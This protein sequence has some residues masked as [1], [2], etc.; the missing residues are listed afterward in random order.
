MNFGKGKEDVLIFLK[1][2]A[3]RKV[4]IFQSCENVPTERGSGE[5]FTLFKKS[6]CDIS[7]LRSRTTLSYYESFFHSSLKFA[8]G[9]NFLTQHLIALQRDSNSF[10]G[11]IG[12]GI[13]HGSSISRVSFDLKLMRKFSQCMCVWR[14]VNLYFRVT[15]CFCPVYC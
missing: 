13:P 12:C 6:L 10:E 5:F 1:I 2:I 3:F 14:G 7:S 15:Y 11:L 9:V 8:S 4:S